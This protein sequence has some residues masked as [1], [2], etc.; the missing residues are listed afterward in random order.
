[1]EDLKQ[2]LQSLHVELQGSQSLDPST[3]E[4]LKLVAEDIR[5]RLESVSEGSESA[6]E[7]GGQSESPSLSQRLEGLIDEFEIQHPRLTNIVSQ[8]VERLADMGI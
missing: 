8:I 1:M 3:L 2:H 4:A 5:I 7:V 6:G